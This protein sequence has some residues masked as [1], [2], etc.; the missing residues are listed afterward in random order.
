MNLATLSPIFNFLVPV[1]NIYD[2]PLVCRDGNRSRPHLLSSSGD[3][4]SM[5]ARRNHEFLVPTN[6][7]IEFIDMPDEVVCRFSVEENRM[8]SSVP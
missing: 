5:I 1:R 6:V 7:I 4:Y 8:I 2:D 3:G